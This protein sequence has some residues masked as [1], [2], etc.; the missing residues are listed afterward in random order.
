[1]NRN[2]IKIAAVIPVQEE[3]PE[4]LIATLDSIRR[5]TLMPWIVRIL[6]YNGWVPADAAVMEAVNN[7]RRFCP[8]VIIMDFGTYHGRQTPAT[9]AYK[10]I[11]SMD[12]DVLVTVVPDI[13]LNQTALSRLTAAFYIRETTWVYG[14]REHLESSGDHWWN[15]LQHK[16]KISYRLSACRKSVITDFLA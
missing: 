11:E 1:M 6:D 4:K 9:I 10:D 5:Q 3:E 7:L 8:N 14:T 2:T 12:Y 15:R 13:V 16:N